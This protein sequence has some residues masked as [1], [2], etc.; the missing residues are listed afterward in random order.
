[1]HTHLHTCSHL[2][3]SLNHSLNHSQM[4]MTFSISIFI[5]Y[6]CYY[7]YYWNNF[8]QHLGLFNNHQYKRLMN[9]FVLLFVYLSIYL[10]LLQTICALIRGVFQKC[11]GNYGFDV[12]NILVGF[13][14]AE[15]V[16]QVCYLPTSGTAKR[17]RMAYD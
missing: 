13:D 7:Y 11:V 16:L 9:G 8:L 1:M 14:S 6:Y 4:V 12:I 3:H 2:M 10:F 15:S 17:L 5:H